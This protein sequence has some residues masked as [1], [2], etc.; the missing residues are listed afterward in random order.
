MLCRFDHAVIVFVTICCWAAL[1]TPA[2]AQAQSRKEALKG[3]ERELDGER[4]LSRENERDLHPVKLSATYY[5]GN[6]DKETIPV[7]LLHDFQGSRRDFKPLID[8]LVKANYAVLAVD[9]RGHGKSTKRYEITPPKTTMRD[10][11]ASPVNRSKKPMKVPVVTPGQRK[12]LDYSSDDFQLEDKLAVLRGDLPLLRKTLE[13]VH[14][15]NMINLNR[16]VV[17][18]VGEG[19]AAAAYWAVHDWRNRDSGRYVKTLVLI[20]PKEVG[21]HGDY[22]KAFSA[23]KALREEVAIMLAVP[24]EDKAAQKIAEKIEHALAPQDENDKKFLETQYPLH[25]VSYPST[26]TGTGTV[27]ETPLPMSMV[28]IFS[29]AGRAKLARAVV[30]FI[31]ERNKNFAN[32]EAKWTRLK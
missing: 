26:K 20:A 15:E 9:L 28:E 17:V 16:L 29:N 5:Y 30:D 8:L 3:Q 12:L 14:S 2:S 21:P 23:S 1:F 27:G 6:A 11:P 32:N 10:L 19:A 7:L 31:A 24:E 13:D 25:V 18:G 22:S 4:F